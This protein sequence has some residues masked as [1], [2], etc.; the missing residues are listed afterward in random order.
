MVS[1]KIEYGTDD[2]ELQPSLPILF[3][4]SI[5]ANNF[6][7]HASKDG[8]D[9]PLISNS[10]VRTWHIFSLDPEPHDGRIGFQHTFTLG[11]V[12]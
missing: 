9:S 7:N 1:Q 12:L 2:W 8:V 3:N 4:M 10:G 5:M 6:F 11:L